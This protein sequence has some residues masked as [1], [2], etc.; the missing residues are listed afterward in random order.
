MSS[1]ELL[2]PAGSWEAM[3]AAVQNGADAI[4][5]GGT[6]FSAR[7]YAN[8]FDL[9]QLEQAIEYAHIRGVRIFLTVNTLISDEELPE[10]IKFLKSLY[11]IGVD[12]VIVQDLGLV[13]LARHLL[14]ELELHASTQMTLHNLQAVQLLFNQGF[15][16]IVLAR[17]TSLEDIKYI[18]AN[19]PAELEVFIHGALC[20]CYSG[21]CLMSSLI[22]GRS[23]NRGHCAQPC[24][25]KYTLVNDHGEELFGGSD[26][27]HILSP[28]DLSTIENIPELMEAGIDSFKIE[29]RMKRPEYVATVVRTYREAIDSFLT[30]KDNF[31]VNP[32]HLKDLKQIFNRDFTPGY[33]LG[34]QGKNMMSYSR[35]NNRGLRLGRIANYDWPNKLA[36][37]T[38]E[39]P[40]RLGDGIEI[41][42]SKGGRKGMVVGEM[43]V[44]GK[45]VE[46]AGPGTTVTIEIAGSIH[47]GDRVFKTNDSLLMQRAIQS[48][49]SPKEIIK[50]PLSFEVTASLGK[51][52]SIKVTD[53]NGWSGQGQTEFLAEKGI[54]RSITNEVIGKQLDRLGNTPY[55]IKDIVCNIEEG[56]MVPLGEINEARR[57][58]L[59]DLELNKSNGN[60][61]KK[62]DT[63]NFK[64]ELSRQ[65]KLIARNEAKPVKAKTLSLN[66]QVG[67]LAALQA[68]VD[69]GANIVY[70]GGDNFKKGGSFKKADIVKARDYC[71]DKGAKFVLSTPRV[72]QP[73]EMDEFLNLLKELPIDTFNGVLV[74][75]LGL[76]EELSK[77]YQTKL[78]GDYSLNV[79]NGQTAKFYESLGC[80]QISLSPELTLDQLRLMDMPSNSELLVQGQMTMMVSE[81]CA[82]GSTISDMT[83]KEK[84]PAPCRKDNYGLRDRMNFVFPIEVDQFCH[85]HI[86]NPKELCLIEDIPH[87]LEAGINNLRLE[88]KR[89]DPYKVR[90]IVSTYRNAIAELAR[91]DF[92]DG[93]VYK[94]KLDK[95]ST[96]GIT[97]GH[98][99]RGVL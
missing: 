12:A 95:L 73:K 88:L 10:A 26:G 80:K 56:L 76:I 46:E 50:I 38:L 2:A 29:G 32:E 78:F 39:E 51:P 27:L 20:I 67:T 30:D 34:Y 41:W 4:Y 55:S 43:R 33:F 45:K 14:P 83:C 11:G 28:R 18:K 25:L 44:E 6:M 22:G 72:L 84:C 54:K 96:N 60:V 65:H 57:L 82:L 21:L 59:A 52:L 91:G 64:A 23:G 98:L 53:P 89:D 66:V 42:V 16:R 8:N 13:R 47:A 40:L 74:A 97:K 5:L 48:Y 61:I 99:Y 94:E 1:A 9:D 90:E 62:V 7:A 24:R 35:P 31:Q 63:A 36:D 71:K 86:F 37:I 93:Q 75:N 70:F 17:E 68:A 49:K 69:S 92:Y 85:M 77:S 79:F 81:Y 58:S 3:V 87:L 15:K 19:C